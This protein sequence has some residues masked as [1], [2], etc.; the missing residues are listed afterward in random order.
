VF[1]FSIHTRPTPLLRFLLCAVGTKK[2]LFLPGHCPP[3]CVQ[4]LF[5][6]HID[7]LRML[8]SPLLEFDSFYV[9]KFFTFFGGPPPPRVGF[10]PTFP[11]LRIVLYFSDYLNPRF[12]FFFE[13]IRQ[14]PP[15]SETPL[16]PHARSFCSVLPKL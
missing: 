4:P 14:R 7:S 8:G 3:I 9:R 1:L 6:P 12:F 11:S 10:P 5:L 2:P 13:H 16:L 15:P